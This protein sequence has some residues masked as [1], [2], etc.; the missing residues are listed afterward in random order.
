MATTK[1]KAYPIYKPSSVKWLG[2]I[3]VHWGVDRLK[4]TIV[5]CTNGMWGSDPE[6]TLDDIVCVR[7]ADF[8]RTTLRVNKDCPTLRALPA[9]ERS[10]RI[11]SR[12]DLLLEKSGGGELQPV[13]AVVI[14]DQDTPAVCSNFVARMTARDTFDPR[15]LTYYHAFSYSSRVNTRSIKQTTGIQNLDASAYLNELIGIPPLPE[16]QAIAA[17]LDR[18]TA[19][20]DGLIEKKRRQI[21]L[22]QEKRAALISHAVTKGL[23]PNVK[24]KPSGIEWLGEIPEH[25]DIVR[26]RHITKQI[27]Q[28]WSPQCE[29]READPDEWGVMKAGCANYGQF[30][31]TEHKALPADVIP[32]TS[33]EIKP[34][35]VIMSRACG[36]I[37]LVGSVAFVEQCRSKLLLCDKLFRIHSIT[38]RCEAQ[39]LYLAMNSKY[40]RAQIEMSLSG[41]G[42]LANNITQ[43]TIK[44]ILIALPPLVEQKQIIDKLWCSST[45]LEALMDKINESVDRLREYRTALISAAVT[46]KIDVRNFPLEMAS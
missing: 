35:D 30:D 10:G 13:G 21:E 40:T 12:G 38:S 17:F 14:Y 8:D 24:M 1:H 26:V 16:Q 34:G 5:T 11:L 31:E 6:G 46:G 2:D 39:Y 23:D 19:R 18:E 4:W 45:R 3:P 33:Y 41:A 43:P 27:E 32:E 15:F 7:V 36:T 44:N 28:G 22:L 42:G 37:S 9:Q 29:S 20:I 25:W